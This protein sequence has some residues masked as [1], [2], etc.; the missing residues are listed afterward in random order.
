MNAVPTQATLAGK[1]GVFVVDEDH[2][3]LWET[4]ILVTDLLGLIE[5][6]GSER[7]LEVTS[8]AGVFNAMAR[9]WWVL[10]RG[11]ELLVRIELERTLVA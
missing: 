2:G 11:D 1:H 7:P 10:P 9:R 8:D 3:L 5:A 4:A 6:C